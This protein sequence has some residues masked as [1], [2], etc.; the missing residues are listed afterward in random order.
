VSGET[1][2]GKGYDDSDRRI[3]NITKARTLLGW[4][5]K[6]PFRELLK[7]TMSY[8]VN[9]YPRSKPVVKAP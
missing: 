5:P 7:A 6:W 2:Y 4:E 1:F 8:Y 9:E 3:P